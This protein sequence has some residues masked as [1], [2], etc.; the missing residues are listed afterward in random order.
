MTLVHKGNIMKYTEGAFRDWGYELAV[1]EFR[2]DCITERESWILDN[3]QKIQ[4]LQLKIMLEKLN[5]V[6]TSLQI[7][8]KHSFAKKLKKLLHQYQI[9]TEME[10]GENLFLLMIG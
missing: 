9:L 5:Q 3:I 8:K 2:E 10:N 4:K 6:L 7:T 1:N